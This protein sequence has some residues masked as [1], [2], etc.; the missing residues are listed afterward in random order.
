[1]ADDLASLQAAFAVAVRDYVRAP[2]SSTALLRRAAEI[3]VEIRSRFE[4]SSGETDWRGTSWGFRQAIS[5]AY[6]QAG[7]LV[8]ERKQAQDAMRY[9]ISIVLR[10]RLTK[11]ELEAAGLLPQS[12]RQRSADQKTRERAV[13]QSARVT[14]ANRDNPVRAMGL[15]LRAISGFKAEQIRALPDEQKGSLVELA[16]SLCKEAER[17][18]RLARPRRR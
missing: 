3:N 13:V 11:D 9:H 1:M 15:A 2:A 5:D 6:G 16:D 18:S 7:L 17:V 12:S 8:S 14:G 10:E 4:N